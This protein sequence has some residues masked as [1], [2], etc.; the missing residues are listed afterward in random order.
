MADIFND[1]G[2]P[3]GSRVLNINGVNFVADNLT[4]TYGTKE[5]LRTNATDEP[6]GSVAIPD[7]T[8]GTAQVQLSSSNAYV[9]EGENFTTNI[10][11]SNVTFLVQSVEVPET[12]GEEKKQSISFIKKY[13]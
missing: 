1:G 8:R 2:V 6:S 7:F 5:I 3:H 11:G 9:T 12:K 13:N 4:V 10:R